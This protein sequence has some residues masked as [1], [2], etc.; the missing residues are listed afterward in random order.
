[1]FWQ[2]IFYLCGKPDTLRFAERGSHMRELLVRG[3]WLPDAFM[4]SMGALQAYVAGE[5][6]DLSTSVESA[7]DTVR[8]VEAIYLASERGGELLPE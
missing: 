6:N 4:G 5:S 8:T 7:F 2:R 3:D 1:V